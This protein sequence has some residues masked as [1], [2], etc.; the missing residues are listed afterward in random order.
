MCCERLLAFFQNVWLRP[1]MR[2]GKEQEV[3]ASARSPC[4]AE[5]DVMPF[6][7][8]FQTILRP[9]L[10][11]QFVM[12]WKIRR[13]YQDDFVLGFGQCLRLPTLPTF[14]PLAAVI[15][16]RDDDRK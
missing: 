3:T 12:F 5:A 16:Q 11:W 15:F 4:S 1:A 14:F 2:L 9:K 13:D 10:R 6:G 8:I 7:R